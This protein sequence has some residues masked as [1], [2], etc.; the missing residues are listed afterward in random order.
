MSSDFGHDKLFGATLEL[1]LVWLGFV[2][3][4]MTLRIIF[5]TEND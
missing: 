3:F 4:N 2:Q 5:K 1:S